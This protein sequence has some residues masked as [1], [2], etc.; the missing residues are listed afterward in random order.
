MYFRGKHN[1]RS[2]GRRCVMMV[3]TEHT[4]PSSTAITIPYIK[5]TVEEEEEVVIATAEIGALRIYSKVKR[6]TRYEGFWSCK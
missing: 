1:E 5:A 3:H 6:R 2:L 4:M